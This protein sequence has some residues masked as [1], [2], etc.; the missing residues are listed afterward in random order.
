MKQ[1]L[2]N[3]H[4]YLNEV[5]FSEEEAE[6]IKPDTPENTANFC[7]GK[8]NGTQVPQ[9]IANNINPGDKRY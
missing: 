9:E 7:K 1:L 8:Q 5:E 2:E 3:F 4:K 6:A